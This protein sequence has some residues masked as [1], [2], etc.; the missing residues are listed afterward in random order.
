[1]SNILPLYQSINQDFPVAG[2]DNDT[3]VFR[4]NFSTIKTCL[5]YAGEELDALQN[6][7]AGAALLSQ[8]NDFNGNVIKNV[9]F[10]DTRDLVRDNGNWNET[11]CNVFFTNGH[12]QI[13]RLGVPFPS[14]VILDFSEFPIDATPPNVG[15]VRLELYADSG[16]NGGIQ[17]VG[18]TSTIAGYKKNFAGTTI[19]V[20]SDTDP[21]ILEVW[22]H[23]DVIFLNLIGQFTQFNP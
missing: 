9:I 12:Y 18:F 20:N 10:Q 22:R 15:K 19:T 11:V 17:T 3:Q 4:D 2:Q 13:F 1:V 5:R 14:N 7:T 16:I 6:S 8:E 21:V 23:S